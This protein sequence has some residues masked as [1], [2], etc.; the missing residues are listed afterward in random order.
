M[1]WNMRCGCPSCGDAESPPPLLK[2]CWDDGGNHVEVYLC[3]CG[4]R[5]AVTVEVLDPSDE[6]QV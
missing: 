4:C 5:F 3:G 2:T 6:E 1:M